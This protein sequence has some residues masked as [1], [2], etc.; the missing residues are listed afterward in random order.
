LTGGERYPT[1]HPD[2]RMIT[3]PRFPQQGLAP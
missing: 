1:M 2:E 3:S